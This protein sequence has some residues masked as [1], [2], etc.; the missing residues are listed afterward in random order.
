MVYRYSGK[1]LVI[2]LN[3]KVLVKY[4]NF[5]KMKCREVQSYPD[6]Q[7]LNYS[8]DNWTKALSEAI[9]F[10]EVQ[11]VIPST[12]ELKEKTKNIK[13]PDKIDC[14][15]KT[16]K[17]LHGIDLFIKRLKTENKVSKGI[18]QS[19][20]QL[21]N[22][23][24]KFKNGKSLELIDL[25]LLMLKKI[26]THFNRTQ[27]KKNGTEFQYSQGQV[28]KLQ[29]RLSQFI[30]DCDEIGLNVNPAYKSSSWK[31]KQPTV[32]G[33]NLALSKEE[34]HKIATQELPEKLSE[35]RNRLLIGIYSG[36]RYSDFKKLSKDNISIKN[37][38]E[39]ITIRQDKTVSVVD[40]PVHSKMKAVFDACDGYP[41]VLSEPQ[42]NLA[43]KEILELSGIVDTIQVERME[44]NTII[45]SDIRK[46]DLISSHTCRRTF[47]TLAIQNN[48]PLNEVMKISGHKNLKTL[49][50]YLKSNGLDNDSNNT[51]AYDLLF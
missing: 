41:I 4:W 10:F 42:F 7:R 20:D 25:D 47:I 33:N 51:E 36:Q 8:I 9:T 23:M 29:R 38:R 37:G 14:T 13:T 40:I 16:N 19:F 44:N 49:S 18:I 24:S 12:L 22:N 6:F 17:V 46:C 34:I 3:E 43:I 31:V 32:S 11:G 27:Q 45:K 35:I 50:T 2:S 21:R 48:M 5:E 1:R 15:E 39:I 30:K 26:I 28:N